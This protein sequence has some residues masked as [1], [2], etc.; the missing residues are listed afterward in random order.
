MQMS[1]SGSSGRPHLAAVVDVA[2]GG[3]V[4]GSAGGEGILAG[5]GHL[6]GDGG[7][8]AGEVEDVDALEDLVPV[9]DVA[10]CH[11]DRGVLAVVDAAVAALRGAN[12]KHIGTK[13]I[14]LANDTRGVDVVD[15]QRT[16][17]ALAQAVGRN[18]GDVSGLVALIGQGKRGVGLG[19]TVADVELSRLLNAQVIFGR[20]P[21]HDL[22]EGKNRFTHGRVAPS[23][24]CVHLVYG[25]G[26]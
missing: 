21:H 6:V 7:R 12:L 8:H 19:A 3:D 5:G 18:N 23:C 2:H 24:S 25:V 15:L 1:T 10:L 14:A 4:L 9:K 26:T 20:E 22:A 13:A 11:V 17:S 16:Q